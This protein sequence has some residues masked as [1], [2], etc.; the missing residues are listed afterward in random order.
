ML[1][2]SFH[3]PC[4][5]RPHGP[6]IS[7]S[8]LVSPS[9][10]HAALAPGTGIAAGRRGTV[11]R[12]GSKPPASVARAVERLLGVREEAKRSGPPAPMDR[13]MRSNWE[14]PWPR[15]DKPCLFPRGW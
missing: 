13:I 9:P 7:E 11:L 12:R 14:S 5:A 4:R 2:L 10:H 3:S 6:I 8:L 15:F 1:V